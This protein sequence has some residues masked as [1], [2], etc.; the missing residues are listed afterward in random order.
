[1]NIIYDKIPKDAKPLIDC[2]EIVSKVGHNKEACIDE[3]N[4]E[5]EETDML[6]TENVDE[7]FSVTDPLLDY[8]NRLQN[9]KESFIQFF[10]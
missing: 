8:K 1:M 9:A 6:L 2:L 7:H 10:E 5:L 3:V 4:R